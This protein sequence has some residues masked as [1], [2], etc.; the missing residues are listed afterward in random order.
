MY[1]KGSEVGGS[2]VDDTRAVRGG[3]E[4]GENCSRGAVSSIRNFVRKHTVEICLCSFI[5]ACSALCAWGVMRAGEGG[6]STKFEVPRAEI[7]NSEL[8]REMVNRFERFLLSKLP[9]ES[10]LK[11]NPR[12][13]VANPAN[14]ESG[15][16]AFSPDVPESEKR[17]M[18]EAIGPE[19]AAELEKR[20]W[21]LRVVRSE[22][23][24][25]GADGDDDFDAFM[26]FYYFVLN[27]ASPF[28]PF[29]DDYL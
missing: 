22:L 8:S 19:V 15:S 4:S 16:V 2:G 6:H 1:D 23:K 7:K 28:S 26:L 5:G 9:R 21:N 10:L 29:N 13:A 17:R 24:T 20:G 18:L 11:A 14:K 12:A 3:N 27:P 25:L